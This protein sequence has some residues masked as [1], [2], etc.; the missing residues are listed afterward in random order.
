MTDPTTTAYATLLG[1][2]ALAGDEAKAAAKSAR[3]ARTKPEKMIQEAQL[4]ALELS[5]LASEIIAAI[6]P[7]GDELAE[8]LATAH[9]AEYGSPLPGT[10]TRL[11]GVNVEPDEAAEKI[12]E[13]FER[14]RK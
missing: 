12:A 9:A 5:H 10:T 11:S 13:K 1:L 3:A 14:K 6:G 8:R 7:A 2:C 4:H